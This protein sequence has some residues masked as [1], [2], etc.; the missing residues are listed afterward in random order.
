MLICPIAVEVDFDLLF[1]VGFARSHHR[2]VTVFLF[3][4]NI[5]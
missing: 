1:K 2:K 5:I 4:I 3:V